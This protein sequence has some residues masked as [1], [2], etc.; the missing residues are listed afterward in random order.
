VLLLRAFASLLR[1]LPVVVMESVQHGTRNHRVIPGFRH[2]RICDRTISL[3][4]DPS[5]PA[6]PSAELSYL[7]AAIDADDQGEGRG[8][9]LGARGRREREK[10]E[11]EFGHSVRC[12]GA[13]FRVAVAGVRQARARGL[14]RLR[15]A[16]SGFALLQCE[17]PDCRD[18]RLVAFS[19]K[20]RGFC[21]SCLG[22]YVNCS[23]PV[24]GLLLV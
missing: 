18:K 1:S 11:R 7:R 24:R 22:H 19:C 4:P 10:D 23:D 8:A 2:R 3:W 15:F 12:S 20:G 13:G 21:P 6:L 16:L 9:R 14:C 17:N 5:A